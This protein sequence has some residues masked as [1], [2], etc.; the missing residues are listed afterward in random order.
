V[1]TDLASR[2]RSFVDGG[3]EPITIDEITHR[4]ARRGSPR[5]RHALVAAALVLAIVSAVALAI[6]VDRGSEPAATSPASSTMPFSQVPGGVSV[7]QFG[8]HLAFVV[9]DD[10]DVTVFD[11]NVHHLPGERALWWCPDEKLFVAPTHAETFSE[12]GRAVGGPAARGLDRLHAAV[13]HGRLVV[14]PTA[15]VPGA[16]GNR[17]TADQTGRTGPGAWDSGPGS[18][19]AG[20]LKADNG[21]PT[22]VVPVE[23]LA[24]AR[25][26]K[27]VYDVSAGLIEMHFDGAAGITLTFDDPRYQYCLLSA[28]RRG[29][30]SCRVSLTPGDYLVYDSVPGHRQAGYEATIRV[31]ESGAIPDT[32]QPLCASSTA[33]APNGSDGVRVPTAHGS[34]WAL[35]FVVKP[36]EAGDSLKVVWR[37]TGSGPLEVTLRDPG[38]RTVPLE[39]GPTRHLSS[40]FGKPGAEWGTVFKFDRSGC[41]LIHLA[42][43]T[44]DATVHVTVAPAG[45]S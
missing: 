30:H 43:G 6:G 41:H 7:Q 21:V 40:T 5:R 1:T 22:A 20:A 19:C 37:V 11:T 45:Q 10:D 27:D 17:H 15:V 2:V 36:L 31:G 44:T 18:F 23:A 25:Y 12:T 28:D 26:D 34:I 16:E 35:P 14:D 3:V 38:G 24:T 33:L 4:H 42:R 8:K 32:T 9:R 39:A 13:R 29:R